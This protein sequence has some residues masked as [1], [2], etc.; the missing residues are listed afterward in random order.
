MSPFFNFQYAERG[1]AFDRS[2]QG[3]QGNAKPFVYHF[4]GDPP[5]GAG[6]DFADEYY[7]WVYQGVQSGSVT[8]GFAANGYGDAR[9][10][11]IDNRMGAWTYNAAGG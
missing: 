7:N 6:E 10:N 8:L 11:W 5:D 2:T 4:V 1:I 9:Y 3:Y